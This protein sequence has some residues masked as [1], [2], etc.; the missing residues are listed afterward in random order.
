MGYHMRNNSPPHWCQT[1][2]W[3]NYAEKRYHRVRARMDNLL[4]VLAHV[5]SEGAVTNGWMIEGYKIILWEQQDPFG[6]RGF[7][8]E[9]AI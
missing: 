1:V 7:N 4:R 5:R 3:F 2:T 8:W 6:R 9:D